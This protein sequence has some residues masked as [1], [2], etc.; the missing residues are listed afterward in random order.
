MT[1]VQS[2][3]LTAV[4]ASTPVKQIAIGLGSAVALVAMT[5]SSPDVRSCRD[6]MAI[7][8]INQTAWWTPGHRP[9]EC[10][11]IPDDEF[12][13]LADQVTGA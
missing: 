12:A 2:P 9:A 11:G 3:R 8:Y 6:A 10:D 7:Q 13:V 5:G 1:K 4:L